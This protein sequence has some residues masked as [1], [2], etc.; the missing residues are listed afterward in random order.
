MRDAAERLQGLVGPVCTL[1]LGALLL[2]VVV[3]VMG[4]IYEMVAGISL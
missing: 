1:L 4:P 2:W 3:S